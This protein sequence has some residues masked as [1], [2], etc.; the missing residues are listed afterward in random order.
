MYSTN[1]TAYSIRYGSSPV[2]CGLT[3]PT[4]AAHRQGTAHAQCTRG[5]CAVGQPAS[6]YGQGEQGRC[7]L[8]GAGLYSHGLYSYGLYSYGLYSYGLYSYGLYSYGLYS[9]GLVGRGGPI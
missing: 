5:A 4:A 7:L 6:D 3:D 8:E 9:Y 1:G 2:A